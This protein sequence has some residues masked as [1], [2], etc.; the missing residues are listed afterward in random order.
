MSRNRIAFDGLEELKAELRRM[1]ESLHGEA[2]H[3][4]EG[5]ANAAAVEVRTKYHVVSG[6]LVQ[7]VSVEK[8]ERSRFYAGRRLVSKS[9]LAQL[10]ENGTQVRHTKLGYNRGRMP[11]AHVFVPAVIRR[12]KRMYEL[13]R[14]MLKRAGLKVFG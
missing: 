9:P 12:R 14:D 5:E 6:E 11:P 7:K 1:P 2:D 3:I 8:V 4:V 13:L 10:Y